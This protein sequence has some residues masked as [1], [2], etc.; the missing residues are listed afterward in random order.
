MNARR[1]LSALESTVGQKIIAGLSGLGL[2]GFVVAHLAG[3]L[4]VFVGADALNK[5]AEKLHDLGPLLWVARIGLLA[6]FTVHIFLTIRLALR[7][8][9]GQTQR[10]AVD[11]SSAST[12][13]SRLMAVSGTAILLFVVFHLLHFTFGYIQPEAKSLVD[14]SGR[15]TST[16]C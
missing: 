15:P 14:V 4:Q 12:R 9:R 13:S 16:R 1:L 8:R 11:G 6:I 7:N 10:Y 5:Y 2:I 3:N